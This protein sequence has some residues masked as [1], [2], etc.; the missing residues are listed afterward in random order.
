[1]GALTRAPDLP[2]LRFP[3]RIM[4]V[5]ASDQ[6]VGDF[7]KDCVAD[8]SQTSGCCKIERDRDQLVAEMATTRPP[9]GMIKFKR[10]ALEAML[11]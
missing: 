4:M 5:L 1:M 9:S 3:Y 6:C 10:P 8:I 2:R 7:V 11:L